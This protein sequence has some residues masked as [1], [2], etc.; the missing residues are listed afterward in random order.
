MMQTN[1]QTQSLFRTA[2]IFYGNDPSNYGNSNVRNIQKLV[3]SCL[4]HSPKKEM[5]VSEI[6][7]FIRTNYLLDIDDSEITSIVLDPHNSDRYIQLTD[8][9]VT[10]YTLSQK[11]RISIRDT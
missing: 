11:R 4:F 8:L 5:T 6:S 10:Q 2:A 7:E 3:E 9:N 1:S